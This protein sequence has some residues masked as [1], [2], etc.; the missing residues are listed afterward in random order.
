MTDLNNVTVAGRIANE[1]ELT[2]TA[3]GVP[4]IALTLA[5]NRQYV[6]NKE[7]VEEVN[8]FRVKIYG[9]IAENLHEYLKKGKS[10]A[11]TG[12]LHQYSYDNQQT[13]FKISITEIIA[14]QVYFL[15]S[16][17]KQNKKS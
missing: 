1:P 5:N 11:I 6:Q 14:N 7:K 10:I 13:G 2:H 8:F 15:G 17:R 3:N 12:R 4:Q 16:F 9:D